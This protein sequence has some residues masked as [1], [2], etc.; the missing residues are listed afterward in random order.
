MQ[1][2]E[3]A[4]DRRGGFKV[5]P[6]AVGAAEASGPRAKLDRSLVSGVAWNGAVRLIGQSASWISTILVAHY[7]SAEDYGVVG[8]AMFFL[9][10]IELVTEF[11]VA[12]AVAI[13]L[14]LTDDQLKQLNTISVGLG[15]AGTLLICVCAPLIG[16]FFNDSRV[17]AVVIALSANF[18]LK[19]FRGVPWGLLARELQ[20]KRLAI[21]DGLQSIALAGLTVALAMAGFRYWTL[22]AASI[23]S[24]AITAGLAV[25]RHPVGFER[26]DFRRLS[27]LVAFS[28][29]I[30]GQRVAWF[31]YS[32][33]D[34]VVAGK[35]LGAVSL[36]YYTLA[37]TLS[38]VT[39]KVTA[40]IL[41]VSPPVLAKVRDNPAEL[42]RYV[43]RISEAISL[44]VLP[45]TV[46]L[47]LV[48]GD[49]VALVLG[50]KWLP[51]VFCLQVLSFYASVGVVL[52]LLAHVLNVTGHE[53]FAMRNNLLQLCVMPVLFAM[54]AYAGGVNGLALA[55]IVGHPFLATRLARHTFRVIDLSFRTYLR[56]ALMPSLVGCAFM[57]VMVAAIHFSW[58]EPS[59]SRGRLIAKIA[60]GGMM[61]L[62][63]LWVLFRERVIGIKLFIAQLR[64]PAA[65]V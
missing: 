33:A 49:F 46:G 65:V 29:N 34:V 19:S 64:N 41:Q 45:L 21:Y 11:G 56:E 20:F 1:P 59:P 9:G 12:S 5:E 2:P 37:F 13:R 43:T 62:G 4:D 35:M 6:A 39:D 17:P 10:L 24:A 51:M 28:G 61:Y 60:A 63:V 26:P 22:V 16:L 54:G 48:A 31:A 27:S 36:G 25:L 53:G 57:A 14:E 15:I 50:A 44:T 32:N 8:M 30:V 38:H 40:L 58:P 42:R 55:W 23:A 3:Q 7:L 47:A 18:L 52:P